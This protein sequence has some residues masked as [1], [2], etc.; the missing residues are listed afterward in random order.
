MNLVFQCFKVDY[1]I[2]VSVRVELFR[3]FVSARDNLDADNF[4]HGNIA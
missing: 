3:V 1:E 2:L 4:D